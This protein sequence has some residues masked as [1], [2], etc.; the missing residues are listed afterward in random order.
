MWAID[1]SAA[2]DGLTTARFCSKTADSSIAFHSTRRPETTHPA[3]VSPG[4]DEGLRRWT[5]LG[6]GS[7]LAGAFAFSYSHIRNI[8]GSWTVGHNDTDDQPLASSSTLVLTLLLTVLY[9]S[10]VYIGA[11]YYRH[12]E[13]PF[14]IRA[15]GWPLSDAAIHSRN[16]A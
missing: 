4:L 6:R 7:E 14:V 12:K 15:A 16:C 9:F 10:L 1:W 8:M 3:G 2:S 11:L 13:W 5:Q